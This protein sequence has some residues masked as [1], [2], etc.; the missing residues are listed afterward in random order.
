MYYTKLVIISLL[1]SSF[2]ILGLYFLGFSSRDEDNLY[3]SDNPKFDLL[4]ISENVDISLKDFEEKNLDRNTGDHIDFNLSDQQL[5]NYDYK[6]YLFLYGENDSFQFREEYKYL[7][8]KDSK[9]AIYKKTGDEEQLQEITDIKLEDIPE[10]ERK[11]LQDGI[12]V[13]SDEELLRILE[14]FVSYIED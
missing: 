5:G 10:R 1:I 3:V 11:A 8:V 12:A 13:K 9:I 14:G 7:G 6:E 4:N 2:F